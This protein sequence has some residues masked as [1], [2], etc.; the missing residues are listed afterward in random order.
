MLTHAHE[1]HYGAISSLI[2]D[3]IDVP[4]FCT[5]FTA[6]LL[7]EKISEDYNDMILDMKIVKDNAKFDVG[8]F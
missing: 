2:N 1:D 8:E 7:K 5:K 3:K 4:I 6:E